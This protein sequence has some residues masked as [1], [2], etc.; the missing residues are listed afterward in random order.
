ME[1]IRERIMKIEERRE[2]RQTLKKL[3]ERKSNSIGCLM[4][5][6]VRKKVKCKNGDIID[7]GKPLWF[8]EL[9]DEDKIDN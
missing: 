9:E 1:S 6:I 7:L 3:Y 2:M 5:L 4:D 8:V